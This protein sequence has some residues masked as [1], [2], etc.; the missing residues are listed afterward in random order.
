VV[1]SDQTRCDTGVIGF[2]AIQ[3]AQVADLGGVD[4]LA[5][6]AAGSMKDRNQARDGAIDV[7]IDAG[8]QC[9]DAIEAGVGVTGRHAYYTRVRE[10]GALGARKRDGAAY[11]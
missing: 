3:Q 2:L 6:R 11:G 10:T 8:G 4:G 5:V 7:H 1:P 9:S